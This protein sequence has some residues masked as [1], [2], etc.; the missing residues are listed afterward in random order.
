MGK[1]K[2]KMGKKKDKISITNGKLV[3]ALADQ[4]YI[5][6]ERMKCLSHVR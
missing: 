2:P 1:Q 3:T 6:P 5:F 4:R